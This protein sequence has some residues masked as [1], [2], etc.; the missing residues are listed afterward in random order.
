MMFLHSFLRG[1]RLRL[2]RINEISDEA[3]CDAGS[4]ISG[5][6]ISGPVSVA[7]GCTI[8]QA[9][10]DG[11]V[12][13]GRFTSLWGPG[14]LISGPMN[15]VNI[16][17]FCSIARHVAMYEASHNPQRTTTYFVEKNLLRVPPSPDA[18]T[19]AGAIRIGNDV[20]I[21]QAAQIMS[22]V[23]VGD[24]A[25]VGAGSI[26]TRDVPPYAVVGGNPARV[27]RYRFD[28]ETIARMQSMA[29]W[30]WEEARLRA[31]SGFLLG[32]HEAPDK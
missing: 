15:G 7:N 13:I 12:S 21:G 14:I 26:V 28:D 17:A 6:R 18:E 20:W 32:L 29:W 4:W 25:I 31:E 8:H 30:D 16:G 11:H 24:G 2:D 19:S 10:L 23:T 3:D 27:I 9:E 22:G 5:S 1:L